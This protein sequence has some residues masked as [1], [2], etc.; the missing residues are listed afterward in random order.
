MLVNELEHEDQDDGEK[1]SVEYLREDAEADEWEVGDEDDCG[2]GGQEQGVE[3]V[4]EFCFLEGF[5]EAALE[6]EALADRVGGG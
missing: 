5:V 1:D 6:A 2:S 4:E 3:P